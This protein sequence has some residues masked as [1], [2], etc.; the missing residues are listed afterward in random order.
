MVL[1][2]D[3]YSLALSDE[4]S[5]DLI[6]VKDVNSLIAFHHKYGRINPTLRQIVSRIIDTRNNRP[7][8]RHARRTRWETVFIGKVQHVGYQ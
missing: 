6:R 5:Q 7:L 3:E 4:C 1:H 2:L 8:F